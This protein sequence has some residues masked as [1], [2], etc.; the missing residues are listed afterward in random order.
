MV[1]YV[2][3]TGTRRDY[4]HLPKIRFISNFKNRF[5]IILMVLITPYNLIIYAT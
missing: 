2:Q 3:D 5:L 4:L 1:E